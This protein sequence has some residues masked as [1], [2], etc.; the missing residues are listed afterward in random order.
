MKLIATLAMLTLTSGI[1]CQDI[2]PD[3][4]VAKL[5][6]EIDKYYTSLETELNA[7]IKQA[8]A[9]AFG[10]AQPDKPPVTPTKKRGYLGVKG[11]DTFDDAAREKAGLK[12]GEG[13]RVTVKPETPAMKA[14]FKDGDII[15]QADGKK[16]T[17][18]NFG[19]LLST[20]SA[21]DKATFKV[22]RDGEEKEI[23]VTMGER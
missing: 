12:K 5:K 22:L 6:K 7:A 9:K 17:D 15:V 4:I 18:K 21:G 23:E 8:V 14:G 11:D 2:D 1:F 16:V 3:K 10:L 20:F 13:L 19:D